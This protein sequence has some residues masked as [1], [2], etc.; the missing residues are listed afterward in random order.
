MRRAS[1][2]EMQ[3]DD[4]SMATAAQRRRTIAPMAD[5]GRRRL[6]ADVRMADDPGPA[7]PLGWKPSRAANAIG[8]HADRALDPRPVHARHDDVRES[9]RAEPRERQAADHVVVLLL[10]D[11][12][13]RTV[14]VHR[15]RG[16]RRPAVCLPRITRRAVALPAPS[17]A[18]GCADGMTLSMPSRIRS[19]VLAAAAAFARLRQERRE[20]CGERLDVRVVPQDL[21]RDVLAV[22]QR[23]HSRV[24]DE[25]LQWCLHSL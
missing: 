16:R 15:Q 24:A 5:A 7:G 19:T 20:T 22:V 17:G 23:L 6:L 2:D 9:C 13:G 10:H 3:D 18:A 14:D 11:G 8:L 12:V 21:G 25:L 1:P 4:D